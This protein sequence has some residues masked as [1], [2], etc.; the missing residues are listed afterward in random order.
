MI[1]ANNSRIVTLDSSR[2]IIYTSGS[3]SSSII[4]FSIGIIGQDIISENDNIYILTSDVN[5]RTS[6]IIN[7]SLLTDEFQYINC[8]GYFRILRKPL[9]QD[10]F[11]V[12][13]QIDTNTY[14]CVKLS[15]NGQRLLEL[16]TIES[17]DDMQINPNDYSVIIAQ[18]YQ[19]KIL[20]FNENGLKISENR[21]IYDPI[22]VFIN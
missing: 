4:N 20:L 2:A 5:T 19:N 18:R 9:N 7:Y 12:G 3:D 16:S 21:T 8:N 11:W 15:Q 10:Y 1:L 14:R 17:I 6:L 13:E 22:K